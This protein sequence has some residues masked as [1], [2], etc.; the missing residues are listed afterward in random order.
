MLFRSLG[1]GLAKWVGEAMG[2]TKTTFLKRLPEEAAHGI[3]RRLKLDAGAFWRAAKG[4][5]FIDWG[6][7]FIQGDFFE[8]LTDG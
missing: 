8:G 1:K 2:H 4:K 7:E 6:P 5:D 3:Q